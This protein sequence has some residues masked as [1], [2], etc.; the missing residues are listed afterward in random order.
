M[1]YTGHVLEVE[2]YHVFSWSW[3]SNVDWISSLIRIPLVDIIKSHTLYT[4]VCLQ[5]TVWKH[6]I[7]WYSCVCI[8]TY[9]YIY[10]I[11]CIHITDIHILFQKQWSLS[12]TAPKQYFPIKRGSKVA[13][14]THPYGYII[15]TSL[16]LDDGEKTTGN[17]YIYWLQILW[18]LLDFPICSLK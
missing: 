8:Y 18:F 16:D 2:F 9:I 10:V 4:D 3:R 7:F 17:P 5:I 6:N 1:Q 11:Q 14:A 12:S 13:G 15:I